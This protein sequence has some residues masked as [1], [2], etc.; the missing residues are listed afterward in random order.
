[1]DGGSDV[2]SV[3]VCVLIE[4]YSVVCVDIFKE[5]TECTHQ[6]SAEPHSPRQSM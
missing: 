4:R 1:V 3:G 5:A 6:S 2:L